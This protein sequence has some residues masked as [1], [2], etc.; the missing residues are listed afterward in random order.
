[1]NLLSLIKDNPEVIERAFGSSSEKYPELIDKIKSNPEELENILS[2]YGLFTF[3]R[4]PPNYDSDATDSDID[5]KIY[6]SSEEK[7]A[8]ERLQALGFSEEVATNAYFF[9]EGNETDAANFLL[10]LAE[11]DYDIE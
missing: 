3:N 5:E 6:I 1:M 8:I 2:E 7:R 4:V 11:E 10:S 9:Y